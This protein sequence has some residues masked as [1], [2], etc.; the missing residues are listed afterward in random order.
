MPDILK[1]PELAEIFNVSI[2]KILEDDINVVKAVLKDNLAECVENNSIMLL[3]AT[4]LYN[5]IHDT[6]MTKVLFLWLLQS[7]ILHPL[8]AS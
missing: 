7:Y 1:L 8:T 3:I 2:D 6:Q 5:F 4:P